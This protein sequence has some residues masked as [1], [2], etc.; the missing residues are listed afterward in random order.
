[1]TELTSHPHEPPTPRPAAESKLSFP[2]HPRHPGRFRRR[3]PGARALPVAVPMAWHRRHLDGD[4]PGL[5]RAGV[6]CT[7]FG[8]SHNQCHEA[9]HL[10]SAAQPGDYKGNR[11][12]SYPQRRV[13][14]VLDALPRC[15]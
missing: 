9:T 15:P 14:A 3:Q 11:W 4:D 12:T 8:P 2:P 1:M 5:A 6:P 13:G 7:P 10:P